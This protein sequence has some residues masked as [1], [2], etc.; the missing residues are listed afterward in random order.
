M[1]RH[2][3]PNTV[4]LSL[5]RDDG[6]PVQF[7]ELGGVHAVRCEG[8]FAE[9]DLEGLRGFE[10]RLSIRNASKRAR[11]GI[12]LAEAPRVGPIWVQPGFNMMLWMDGKKPMAISWRTP[13]EK[14]GAPPPVDPSLN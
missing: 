4:V 12:W 2:L 5:R 10:N 7:G 8:E 11:I 3:P 14:G 13:P 1:N 9:I 6:L